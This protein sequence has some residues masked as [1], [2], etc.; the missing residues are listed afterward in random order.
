MIVASPVTDCGPSC[1]RSCGGEEG[2]S[3]PSET[4]CLNG[5]AAKNPRSSQ[6]GGDYCDRPSTAASAAS[7]NPITLPF[8]IICQSSANSDSRYFKQGTAPAT[9]PPKTITPLANYA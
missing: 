6:T 7:F 3:Q 5:W 8:A 2:W 4:S 1:P 9:L